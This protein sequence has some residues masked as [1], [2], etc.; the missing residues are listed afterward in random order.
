LDSAS[1]SGRRDEPA[2][3]RQDKP[4]QHYLCDTTASPTQGY[5]KMADSTP[6]MAGPSDLNGLRVLVVED[7]WDVGMGLKMLLESWGAEIAGPAATT[8]DAL[9]LLSERTPDVAVVDI[10]LRDGERSHGLIDQLHDRG[11]RIVVI[12]GYEDVSPAPGKVAAVLKKPVR[13]ELLL[14]SLRPDRTA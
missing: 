7:S 10:N 8:A 9:R 2:I 3:A 11:I 4:V 13:E 12:S 5:L 1:R 14:A 6:P